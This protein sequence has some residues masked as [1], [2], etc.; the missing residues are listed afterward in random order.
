METPTTY[1]NFELALA[2]VSGF[3]EGES[4]TPLQKLEAWAYLIK[5]SLIWSKQQYL[6]KQAIELIE[7]GLIT[8]DG[9]IN[10]D[11]YEE[12]QSGIS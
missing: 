1:F 3:A 4:A 5:T 7:M 10:W 8:E 2:Y 11:I 12:L 9:E 6:Q